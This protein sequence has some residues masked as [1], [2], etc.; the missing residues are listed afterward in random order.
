M[1]RTSVTK[2]GMNAELKDSRTRFMMLLTSESWA[3]LSVPC[4][5]EG[6]PYQVVEGGLG[7]K[8]CPEIRVRAG[9]PNFATKHIGEKYPKLSPLNFRYDL[10][11]C[12]EDLH[13]F[14]SALYSLVRFK[15]TSKQII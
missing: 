6:L 12:E 15:V 4:S 5:Q 9:A 11:I 14:S 8:I 1:T 10:K 7:H 13:E 3:R 2:C